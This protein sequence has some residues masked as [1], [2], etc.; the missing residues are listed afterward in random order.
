MVRI[1]VCLCMPYVYLG[2]ICPTSEGMSSQLTLEHLLVTSLC[3]DLVTLRQ[4]VLPALKRP[5]SSAG[6]DLVRS[7]DGCL[8]SSGSHALLQFIVETLL[9][10]TG[11]MMVAIS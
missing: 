11:L 9:R 7:V 2:C 3:L 5:L 6:S 10:T 4:S 8:V 1:L